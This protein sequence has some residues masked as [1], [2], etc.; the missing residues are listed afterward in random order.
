MT[1]MPNERDRR[2][3]YGRGPGTGSKGGLR[4]QGG[5]TPANTGTGSKGGTP[6]AHPLGLMGQIEDAY[7]RPLDFSGAQRVGIGSPSH[8]VNAQMG[9]LPAQ[10]NPNVAGSQGVDFTR[11]GGNLD[12]LNMGSVP[13]T[14]DSGYQAVN[15]GRG[16]QG[17]DFTRSGAFGGVRGTDFN[18][19]G[20][21]YS[22]SRPG[23]FGA[24]RSS[25]ERSIF[26][27]GMNLLRPEL[28]RQESRMNTD[29]VNR[30]LAPTSEAY[31]DLQQQF[32]DRRGRTLNDLSLASVMAGA[33]EHQRLSD[34]TSRNRAQ[35][36]QEGAQRFGEDMG[37]RQQQANEAAQ[38]ASQ[39]LGL[40]GIEAGEAANIMQGQLGLRGQQQ[41]FDQNQVQNY[42]QA[43]GQQFGQ[44]LSN[45]Q[46][47]LAES[48][49]RAGQQLGLRGLQGQELQNQFQNQYANR[50]QFAGEQAQQYGQ[51]MGL[52]QLQGAEQAQR[53]G[54]Q[55][56]LRQQQ[57][58]EQMMQ[59]TQPTNDL[60]SLLSGVAPGGVPTM[61]QLPQYAIQSPDLLGLAGSNY[62]AQ[63]GAGAAKSAGRNNMIGG[64]IGGVGSLL[65]GGLF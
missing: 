58:T 7:A 10:G 38:R 18:R 19:I 65:G 4:A 28:E 55:M 17:V 13:W 59:R 54:Q 50:G 52:R 21:M 26:D 11:M 5:G 8:G 9:A 2:S 33:Q 37:I 35:L 39:Q 61:P 63:Q 49:A 56:G 14:D 53:F 6:G 27:R 25:I 45:Q 62:A 60:L 57:I 43:Q 20:G 15:F 12:T 22:L 29:L 64:I 51:D 44:G 36:A 24:E 1:S 42:L 46:Q 40:R 3:E 23:D 48:Q 41:A 47:R 31:G 16:T 32:S 34:L 30:G